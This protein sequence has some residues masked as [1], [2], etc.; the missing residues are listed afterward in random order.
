MA[1]EEYWRGYSPRNFSLSRFNFSFNVYESNHQE[2]F[3]RTSVSHTWSNSL[4]NTSKLA[5]A[6]NLQAVGLCKS[7]LKKLDGTTDMINNP[8]ALLDKL[9]TIKNTIKKPHKKQNKKN[10]KQKIQ[11]KSHFMH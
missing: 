5:S 9:Q 6:S 8:I 3:F 7:K 2:L 11:S 10:K 4:K 1:E